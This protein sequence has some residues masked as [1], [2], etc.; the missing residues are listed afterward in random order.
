MA[1]NLQELPLGL[2]AVAEHNRDPLAPAR[3]V[4]QVIEGVLGPTGF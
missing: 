1:L 4:E 3:R 2:D